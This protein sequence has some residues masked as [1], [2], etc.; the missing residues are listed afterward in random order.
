MLRR[1]PQAARPTQSSDPGA[2]EALKRAARSENVAVRMGIARGTETPPEILYFLATDP[3]LDVRMA[4]AANPSTPFQ[5]DLVLCA[6]TADVVRGKVAIKSAHRMAALEEAP[7]AATPL[8]QVIDRLAADQKPEIRALISQGVAASEAV[9]RN[10]ACRLATD[11]TTAV[12]APMLEW[13]PVLGDDDLLEIV[14]GR[15]RSGALA[16]IARRENLATAVAAAVAETRDISAMLG[17]VRNVTARITPE[18]LDFIV[19]EAERM[20]SIHEPLIL[21]DELPRASA[22]RMTGFVSQPLVDLIGRRH[23][24][25]SAAVAKSALN[26]SWGMLKRPV[27]RISAAMGAPNVLAKPA[28][29]QAPSV[30]RT[31]PPDPTKSAPPPARSPAAAAAAAQEQ[32][33][34]SQPP[35]MLRARE[36][37]A[38][39]R[40]DD[41]VVSK[42]I[43]DDDRDFVVAALTIRTGLRGLTVESILNS[44]RPRLVMALAWRAS[45]RPTTA[46]KLQEVTARIDPKNVIRPK[47]GSEAYP[48]AS[49]AMQTELASLAV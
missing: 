34:S 22:M 36:L 31:A 38:L 20:A 5:A 47:V 18:T 21:R 7:D 19:R 17:L 39:N 15:P 14:A 23:G 32:Q 41:L 29:A 46:A 40:L 13:S 35:A 8:L 4:V 1:R 33:K 2:W 49:K 9:P 25:V 24:H 6:D 12:A 45:L 3:N 43:E 28:V 42:A 37:A 10:L 48:L 11:Q 26:L 30:P 16:A 27:D 44:G